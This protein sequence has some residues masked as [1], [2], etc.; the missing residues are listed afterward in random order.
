[1]ARFLLAFLLLLLGSAAAR[2]QSSS[3]AADIHAVA[4][5]YQLELVTQSPQFPVRIRSGVIDGAEADPTDVESYLSIFAFE[6][7]LYPADLVQRTGLKRVV[8]C[9]ELSF[10]RQLRTGVPDFENNVLYLDVK[11]GRHDEIYVRKVIHHEFFHIIDLRDDGKLYE[12]ERWCRLNPPGFK[13][14]SGG[15]K[16]QHDP[17]V[18]TTGNDAPGFFNRYAT[19]GVEEDKAE[20]FAHLMVEPKKV[21]ERAKADKYMR[22]KVER[23]TELLAEFSPRVNASF[24]DDVQRASR[25]ETKTR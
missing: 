21:A 10:E 9:K 3:P 7:S 16:L 2:A 6:W 17:T 22:A 4:R 15:A 12:D 14:G 13:Y 19:A 8:F 23:M 5:K 1:M 24:W 20:V 18:T 25:Q 11:R